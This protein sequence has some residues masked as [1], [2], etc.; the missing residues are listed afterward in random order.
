ML[1]GNCSHH[2]FIPLPRDLANELL[3][4]V[5]TT[6]PPRISSTLVSLI[7]SFLC[8]HDTCLRTEMRSSR[9]NY[10]SAFRTVYSFPAHR[11]PKKTCTDLVMSHPFLCTP[12]YIVFL[13]FPVI[14]AFLRFGPFVVPRAF[15]TI[16]FPIKALLFDFRF[17]F[18]V[19]KPQSSF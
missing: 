15:L 9:C 16:L 6:F 2:C 14:V 11:L 8:L 19:R 5:G 18:L 7:I 1:V 17:F 4:L 3:Q 12:T 13:S 10:N